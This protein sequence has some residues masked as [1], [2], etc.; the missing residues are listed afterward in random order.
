MNENEQTQR[1]AF[2]KGRAPVKVVFHY[3]DGS[4]IEKLF[5]DPLAG[6]ASLEK[7]IEQIK[8]NYLK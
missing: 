4:R 3:S 1:E 2:A 6:I 8:T 5:H 7:C